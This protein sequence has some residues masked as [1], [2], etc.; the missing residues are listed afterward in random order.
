MNDDLHS[1]PRFKAPVERRDFLGI[2]AIGSATAA[3]GFAAVGAARL[4][5]PS[6]FPEANTSVKLGPP[7]QFALVPMTPVPEHRLWVISDS[8]GLYA[9]SAV[10]T[11]LGCV[12]QRQG[13]EGFFCPCHGSRFDS[14]GRPFAGPAPGPLHY[15][16]LSL[17]ADGQLVVDKQAQVAPDVRL[18]LNT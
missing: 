6:V 3:I 14:A 1:S 8:E 5:M 2:A 16:K 13:T 18:P 17:S 12:V 15:L 9:L 10:C 4:P 11:H 7:S